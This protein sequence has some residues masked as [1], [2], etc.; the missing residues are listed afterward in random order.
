[1]V[2]DFKFITVIHFLLDLLFIY[3]FIY[4]HNGSFLVPTSSNKYESLVY[5]SFIRS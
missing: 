4:Y 3:L 1:M 2:S 5:A